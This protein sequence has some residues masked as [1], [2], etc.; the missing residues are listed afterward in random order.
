MNTI[1][2]DELYAEMERIDVTMQQVIRRAGEG[3]A[4]DVERRLDTHMRS[5]R[6]MLGN[7]VATVVE[8]AVE[9]AKRVLMS[10]E[11]AAPLMMLAMSRETLSAVLRRHA[12]RA[13]HTDLAA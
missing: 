10:A 7:D 1:S 12:M 3:P 9:A 8:D 2:A 13:P 6:A 11:P 5:L 4:P